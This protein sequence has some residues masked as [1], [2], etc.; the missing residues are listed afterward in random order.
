LRRILRA[1]AQPQRRWP[2][3]PPIIAAPQGEVA[4][5]PARISISAAAPP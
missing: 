1:S 3:C 4:R 5:E 2:G